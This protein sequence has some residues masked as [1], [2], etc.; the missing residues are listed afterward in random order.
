[1]SSLSD[2]STP[3]VIAPE[4]DVA[5]TA[6]DEYAVTGGPSGKPSAG[7]QLL[8]E[9]VETVALFAVIFTLARITIGNYQIVGQSMEPNYFEQERLLVDRVSP[10]LNWLERGD[11]VI[12]LS[13]QQENTE[14]IKRLIG[15]PGDTIELRDNRVLVNGN[16]LSEPYLRPDALSGPRS[17][18]Q[19]RWELGEDQYFVMGDNRTHSQDSRAFGPIDGQRVAGRALIVYWPFKDFKFVQ[20]FNYK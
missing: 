8:K 14:L 7:A 15:K 19:T 20:H 1:M 13:P 4:A 10:R 6:G 16:A 17:S 3:G 5:A 18:E 9:I 11:I 2:V 12:V